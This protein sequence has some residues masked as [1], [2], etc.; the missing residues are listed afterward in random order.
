MLI[1]TSISS[2][3]CYLSVSPCLRSELEFA[4]LFESSDAQEVVPAA[5]L[6]SRNSA[7]RALMNF[8][9]LLLQYKRNK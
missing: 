6:Y 3:P 7:T 4:E 1:G 5:D 9:H 2:S 8:F